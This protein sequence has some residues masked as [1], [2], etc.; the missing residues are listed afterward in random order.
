MKKILL[1][2]FIVITA[3]SEAQTYQKYNINLTGLIHPNPGSGNRYSGC[4][5][6]KQTSTNKEYAILGGSNGTYFVDVTNPSTPSVSAYVPG[7]SNC[8]WREIK[9]YQN[10]CY[11]ISDDGAPNR[12]QIIDMSTLPSTVTV[13]HDGKSL[14]E[15]GHAC[16]INQDKFY[17]ASV[18]YS[19]T[20]F[21][22]MNVYSLATPTAPVLLRSLEQDYPFI[23]HVHDMFVENDT[24]FASCGYQGLYL[25]KFNTATNTFTQIGSHT[26]YSGG[27]YNHSGMW[28]QD[29]KHFL[30]CDEV[31]AAQ[32]IRFVNIQNFGN[33]QPVQSFIPNSNTTPH[34]PYLIGNQWAIVSC[35][36]DGLY[37]YDIS[38]PGNAVVSGYFDTY[39]Q[40]GQNTGNYIGSAY[41]GNWGAYPW[42][43]SGIILALDMYNGLFILDG[44]PA[45]SNPV[46]VKKNLAEGELNVYPNPASAKVVVQYNS[47]FDSKVVMKNMLGQTVF[48]KQFTGNVSEE[49]NVQNIKNGSYIMTITENDRTIN[50]KLLVTH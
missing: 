3:L 34:N 24:V 11:V 43:P 48:E 23:N 26:N 30:F 38:Q 47:S 36:Q 31:P 28:T 29:R 35:Y 40:G 32:P 9:T 7:K 14:F 42:L 39:P 25:F 8:T 5:G 33:I 13:V 46:G 20:A 15:R 12:F 17:V 22:S 50:K 37:I 41:S 18:T 21:S 4:W 45:F 2:L 10:Y 1:A 44:T 16:W 6:W 27:S 19:N 49:I